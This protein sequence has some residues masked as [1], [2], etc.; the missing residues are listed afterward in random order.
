MKNIENFISSIISEASLD[1]RIPDGIVDINNV[2]HIM[3]LAEIVYDRCGDEE[4]VNEFLESMIGEGKY[5]ERQAFNKD[6]W[7][8]TF[9]S[10]EYRDAALKK[11]THSVS[12][13]TH[14]KGGMN[15]Y[16]KK[17]GK[18]KRQTQQSTST[19]QS[20]DKS[21]A[22][23][24]KQQALSTTPVDKNAEPQ[25][26]KQPT[27]PDTKSAIY[28]TVVDDEVD[29][30]PKTPVVKPTMAKKPSP[31]PEEQPTR[32]EEPSTEP[33]QQAPEIDVPVVTTP[34]E[35]YSSVSKKFAEKKGWRSELYGEYIDRE[36]NTVAVVGMSGEI[37]PIR[38]ID[39]DEYKL[40][41]E[42]L[43]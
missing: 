29:D 32:S 25:S 36:G 38:S 33:T 18:Q 26:Q 27:Q 3:V 1:N 5:P 6:G 24:A 31:K 39:R 22:P 9:P 37:V 11:G 41:A 35:Q 8:V 10:K 19:V 16:Y 7:L 2:S 40:F 28:S 42:K 30:G 13:P 23:V 4:V 17:K 14:G 21:T 20:T 12:D 43:I 34:P 15:L